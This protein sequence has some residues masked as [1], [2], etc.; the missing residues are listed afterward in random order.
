MPA[1]HWLKTCW[2]GCRVCGRGLW[3]LVR[4]S[5]WLLLIFTA[6]VQIVILNSQNLRVPDFLLRKIESNLGAAG[7][8]AEFGDVVFD[9]V[10]RILLLDVDLSLAV[11][12]TPVM[13]ADSVYL[14]VDP[15]ALWW[16]EFD[17]QKVS[18]SG[19][20]LLIPA[21]LSPSG[22]SEALVSD[23]DATLRPTETRGM[24][25][26]DHFTARV[27]SIPVSMHGAVQLPTVRSVASKPWDQLMSRISGHYVDMCRQASRHFK[28]LPA[29]EGLKLNLR[30]EPDRQHLARVQVEA[31]TPTL[32]L[33]QVAE[34]VPAFAFHQARLRTEFSLTQAS[35]ILPLD[36]QVGRFEIDDDVALS[37]L[38]IETQIELVTGTRHVAGAPLNVTAARIEHPITS[39]TGVTVRT[40]LR[41][42]PVLQAHVTGRLGGEPI[43]I[44]TDLDVTTVAGRVEVAGPVGSPVLD[45]I[46]QQ[47]G[48]DVPSI[49]KWEQSPH[50]RAAINLGE[51][52]KPLRAEAW[53]ST[54]EVEARWV[55]LTATSARVQ[56]SGTSLL[57]DQIM[58][59]TG[60]SLAL[61]SYEMDTET[62]DFR[63]LLRGH[64]DPPNIKGWFRD[65]WTKLFDQF[66]FSGGLPDANVEVSGRWGDKLDT[67]VFVRADATNPIVRDIPM[68]RMRT[69]L[70]TRPGWADVMHF[71]AE[72]SMGDVEGTFAR[73][74]R[75]PDSRRW[76]RVEIHAGGVTDL[77]PAPQLLR[78]TGD[79]LIEPF[80]FSEPM[81]L[82]LDGVAQRDDWGAPVTQS[83]DITGSA[84]GPWSFKGFPFDGTSFSAQRD[85]DRILINAFRAG[86]SDGTLEGRIELQGAS[87][88]QQ[89]AF[90]LNLADA[91]LG[92]TMHDVTAWLAERRGE[93][94]KD[95]TEFE[96]QMADGRLTLT[97]TAEGPSGDLLG[98]NGSGSAAITDANFSNINLFGVLSA[99][100]ER[101]ILNFSTLQL[102][103]ANA[104]FNLEGPRL[105]FSQIKATGNRGAVD[106]TGEYSL[107]DRSLD[108]NTRVRPFEGGEGLLDAVFTPFSSALEVKLAGELDDPEWTFVYG[109][110]N[111]LRNLTGENARNRTK[112][113]TTAD[114]A[115]SPSE[116]A[117]TP[118][119]SSGSPP[120]TSE[121]GLPDTN[122]E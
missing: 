1:S 77:S 35:Q 28:H 62:L 9:P 5:S 3:R 98:L 114:E 44:R 6:V 97:L 53:F 87:P 11:I 73:Q 14:E 89:V 61:G 50:L 76:T 30:L 112:P 39:V 63:F 13:H 4:W 91:S 106:A 74:W 102:N 21:V 7:L 79:A 81:Q 56:W 82:R 107:A 31:I 108:F 96:K 19:V 92:D 33:P 94:P 101:T 8:Q 26:L 115:A 25:A 120:P 59:R 118:P 32:T 36:L 48:F 105:V 46:G 83:F 65:W 43:A 29:L 23:I 60:P 66:D 85:D 27:G 18:F 109:P 110:I 38:S 104:D 20:D 2:Q 70:F 84:D 103:H 122:S 75:M 45:V 119:T 34:S 100:L 47:I 95:Q 10:G 22:K 37:D 111:L 67:R 40:D 113:S 80:E 72:R 16:R 51:N 12:G 24:L 15:L 58:L 68:D 90:D 99:L 121:E 71:L 52:A 69:R 117:Q 78:R 54:A 17:P 116:H 55:P 41:P 49:L 86:M 42:L 88:D 93:A 64:L 57:A